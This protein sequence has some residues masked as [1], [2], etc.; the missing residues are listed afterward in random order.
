MENSLLGLSGFGN[1]EG[2]KAD[3]TVIYCGS[4]NASVALNVEWDGGDAKAYS[5]FNNETSNWLLARVFLSD[6]TAMHSV[7]GF[8]IMPKER[9]PLIVQKEGQLIDY[10]LAWGVQPASESGAPI[11]CVG[12]IQKA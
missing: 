9:V 5:L 8:P 4:K 11:S 1:V 7:N 12:G 6:G 2:S 3:P 10:I